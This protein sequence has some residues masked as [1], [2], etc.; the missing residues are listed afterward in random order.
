[1]VAFFYSL[2]LILLEGGGG[3]GVPARTSANQSTESTA[4]LW[5]SN[6]FI[7][8]LLKTLPDMGLPGFGPKIQ[9]S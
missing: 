7:E 4:T 6:V 3:G 9:F 1:M 2:F 5:N 8:F